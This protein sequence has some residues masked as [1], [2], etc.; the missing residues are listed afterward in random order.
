VNNA[1]VCD[2]A[3]FDEISRRAWDR[4]I[5]VSLTGSYLMSQAVLPSMTARG[6]G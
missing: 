4:D 6:A 5:A 1:A 2:A 3:S